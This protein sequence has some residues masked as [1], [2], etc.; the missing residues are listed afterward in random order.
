MTWASRVHQLSRT[1]GIALLVVLMILLVISTSMATLARVHASIALRSG[2]ADRARLADETALGLERTLLAWADST[3]REV[4]LP[5]DVDVP[6]CHVLH[7]SFTLGAHAIVVRVI[8]ID[9]CGLPVWQ[10]RRSAQRTAVPAEVRRTWLATPELPH[11]GFDLARSD[12][13]AGV[14]VFPRFVEAEL[15]SFPGVL[16]GGADLSGE[17]RANLLPGT[18]EPAEEADRSL[19]AYV[20]WPRSERREL[21][22]ATAPLALLE[23]ESG[24]KEPTLR[25]IRFDREQATLPR[26]PVTSAD[27]NGARLGEERQLVSESSEWAFSIDVS[28]DR[29]RRRWW[30]VAHRQPAVNAD[31]ED[32]GDAAQGPW[33]I[34]QRLEVTE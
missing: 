34:V 14:R 27:R 25:E 11:G 29:V 3:G 18:P 24:L 9:Q 33:R 30:V 6:G 7:D 10:A 32:G 15:D 26:L 8:A 21:N 13:E 22:I 17:D 31:S 23:R 19:A 1:R 16:E 2:G 12:S 28:V 5:P 4:V 20:A